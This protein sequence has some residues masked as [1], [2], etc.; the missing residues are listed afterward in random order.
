MAVCK[1]C[2][3]EIPDG[4]RYCNWCG[5]P[6]SKPPRRRQKAT[7]TVPK[8][9]EVSPGSWYIRLRL[10][11]ESIAVYEATEALCK[12]KATAIKAG[13]LEGK[14]HG[15]K[16]TLGEAIDKYI[17]DRS[18]VLSPS[19]LRGYTQIR[20]C[21]FQAQMDK[22]LEDIKDWQKIINREAGEIGPKTLK[23]AWGLVKSVL[24]ENGVLVKSVKLPQRV[25]PERP[26]LDYEQ[27]AT[28][29]AAAK[30]KPGELPALLALHS[31]RRS[32]LCAVTVGDVDLTAG[33]IRVAG[34]AVYSPDGSLIYKD[35]NKNTS[36]RRVIPI[37][38]PRLRQLLEGCAGADPAERIITVVP[39]TIYTQINRICS[40]AG[41][42]EVGVHGL[43]HSF[44]SLAYHLGMSE[45]ETMDLGGW[46]DAQTVHKIYLHLAQQD[47]LS[48]ANKMAGFY[49][50]LAQEQ[51]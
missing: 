50:G 5:E 17:S 26:W 22:P 18:A 27:I 29:L 8:A 2:R 37:M 15:S 7:I 9:Q 32:E 30:D 13:F 28:F 49:A 40:A 20:H 45:R 43:R 21:R 48:S 4:S 42:P 36:S 16:L 12:A 31:L 11:G 25:K 10:G 14:K 6:Q 3:A 33:T 24:D 35:T 41:L 44:A 46:S 47:R 23:N 51:G 39:N 19:T 34:A 1:K 38:I